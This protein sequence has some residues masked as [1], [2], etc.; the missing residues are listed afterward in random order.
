M[1]T[2]KQKLAFNKMLGEPFRPEPL[3]GQG[4]PG[5]GPSPNKSTTSR[6]AA[7]PAP[8]AKARPGAKP[9]LRMTIR[10]FPLNFYATC[11]EVVHDAFTTSWL[12]LCRVVL[13]N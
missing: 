3:G 12:R 2:K 6:A 10:F 8:T 1:P 9:L 13:R 7:G 11:G 4:G 5:T